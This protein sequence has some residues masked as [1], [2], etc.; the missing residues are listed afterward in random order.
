VASVAYRSVRRILLTPKVTQGVH[1]IVTNMFIFTV[2][3]TTAI[4]GCTK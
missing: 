1:R 4:F 2:N 3:V